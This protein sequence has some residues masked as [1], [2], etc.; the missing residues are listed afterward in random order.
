[1]EGMDKYSTFYD[2]AIAADKRNEAVEAA[3]DLGKRIDESEK[4]KITRRKSQRQAKIEARK[5]EARRRFTLG[6]ISGALSIS[7]LLAGIKEGKNI[8]KNHQYKIAVNEAT[9]KL[10]DGFI[11]RA[12]ENNLGIINENGKLDTAS[13]IN[14]NDADPV[15]VYTARLVM[16][17]EDY[18]ESVKGMKTKDGSGN[19]NDYQQRFR[20]I[21][22][23]DNTGTASAEVEAQ[24]LE[25]NIY[26][27]YENA[28][29][30]E[31]LDTCSDLVVETKEQGRG[32]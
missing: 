27:I 19:Y 15:V 32:Y 21:G 17:P 23:V 12:L 13:P 6:F 28:S 20:D 7:L 26:T 29:Y 16:T 18:N 4:E 10:K 2:A 11:N 9:E 24:M 5:K 3:N 22:A 31:I 30:N 25:Q 14:L 8:I 1:M